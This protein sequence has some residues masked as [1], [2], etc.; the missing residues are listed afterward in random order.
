M[1]FGQPV[2]MAGGKCAKPVKLVVVTKGSTIK[3]GRFFPP[4]KRCSLILKLSI[5]TI[6]TFDKS[7][8]M[9]HNCLAVF[10]HNANKTYCLLSLTDI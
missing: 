10:L 6:V 8:V 5:F 9:C 3:I 4:K 1:I 2:V 7:Q